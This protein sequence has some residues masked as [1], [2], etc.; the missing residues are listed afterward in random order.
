MNC[1]A[2]RDNQ[3][4]AWPQMRR[5]LSFVHVRHFRIRQREKND[6]RVTHSLGCIDNFKTGA[7]RSKARFAFAIKPNDDGESAVAQI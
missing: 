1:E 7:P 4:L 6:I 3:R 5:D 2:V